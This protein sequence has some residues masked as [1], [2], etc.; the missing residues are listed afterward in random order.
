MKLIWKIQ[1]VLQSV[2]LAPKGPHSVPMVLTPS[3]AVLIPSLP[4]MEERSNPAKEWSG[5][6]SAGLPGE[7]SRTFWSLPETATSQ[8]RDLNYLEIWDP[9]PLNFLFCC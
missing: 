1:V 5:A 2:C 4:D 9:R 8:L 3:D 7:S 6:L